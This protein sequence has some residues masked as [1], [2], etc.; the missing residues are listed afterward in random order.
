VGGT[1]ETEAELPVPSEA[2]AAWE[3]WRQIRASV[4]NGEKTAAIAEAAAEIGQATASSQEL[5][6]S[7]ELSSVT[8]SPST[9]AMEDSS[10]SSIVDSVLAELKPKLMEEIAKKLSAEK[11]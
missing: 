5:Q 1:S 4:M 11:K 10:L 3:N 8:P 2:A 6:S 9:P 7:A